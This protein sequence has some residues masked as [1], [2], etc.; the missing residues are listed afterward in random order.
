[1]DLKNILFATDFGP[2]AQQAAEYAFSLAQEHGAHLTVLHVVEDVHAYTEEEE[3]RLRKINI[4]RMR[5]LVPDE[6]ENWCKVE[7]RVA[8]G[9][10]TEEIL[11][12]ARET[13]ADLVVMG[14]KAGSSF[15]GHALL[16][17]AYYV[18]TKSKCPV[19]TVRG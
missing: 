17:V 12:E 15:A 8:F 13:K 6:A 9:T 5:N 11:E 10:A 16:T 4:Q 3:E 18:V 1:V 19:F 2:G 14:A 7:F